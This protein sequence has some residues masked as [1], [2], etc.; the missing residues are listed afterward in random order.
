MI[1]MGDG[2]WKGGKGEREMKENVEQS[3]SYDSTPNNKWETIS[4]RRR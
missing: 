2:G 4:E 1:I 3:S